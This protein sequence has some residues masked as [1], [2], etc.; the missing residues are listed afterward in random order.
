MRSACNLLYLAEASSQFWS[1]TDNQDMEYTLITNTLMA[2]TG[3]MTQLFNGGKGLKL[4]VLKDEF[5]LQ[6][7]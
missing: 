7:V 3:Y 4:P 6:M 2:Y 1:P 5:T